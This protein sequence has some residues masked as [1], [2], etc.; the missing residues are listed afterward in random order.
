MK[1]SMLILLEELCDLGAVGTIADGDRTIE[2]IRVFAYEETLSVDYVYIGSSNDFF[3]DKRDRVLLIHRRDIIFVDETDVSVVLNR[4]IRIFDK[5]RNWY[6]RI[7]SARHGTDPFQNILDVAHEAF[8]CPMFIGHRNLRI[9][10]LTEQYREHEVYIGWDDVKKQR[11]MPLGL[12]RRTKRLDMRKY[13][14]DVDPIIIPVEDDEAKYFRFQIRANVYLSGKIWGHLYLYWGQPRVPPSVLQLARAVADIYGKL[15]E[16]TDECVNRYDKFSFLADVL[17]GNALSA[18][19]VDGYYWQLDWRPTDALVL[20]KIA[21]TDPKYD[22]VI[23]DWMCDNIADRAPNIIIFPYGGSVVV[24]ERDAEKSGALLSY[25]TQLIDRG[26]YRCGVSFPFVGLRN[27]AP[28]FFQAGHAIRCCGDSRVSHFRDCAPSGIIAA[29]KEK[30][31]WRK[32]ILPEL[33]ALRITDAENGTDYFRT[34]Q[35]LLA[36]GGNIASAAKEL[37]IHR[38]TVKYRLG[39]LEQIFGEGL[40]GERARAYLLLCFNLLKDE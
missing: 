8:N 35:Y 40:G 27:I 34:L 22:M 3:D 38:N 18:E 24:I 1:L 39:K 2:S 36:A 11:T 26:D 13:P 29:I 32:F 31:P 21:T 33:L 5:Y 10:A 28:Y 12:L 20:Y 25:I 30:L 19:S 16:S 17:D 14:D 37:F 9:Y 23:L 15:L 4:V 7:N 6:D